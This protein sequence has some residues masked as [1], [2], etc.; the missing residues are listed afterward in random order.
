[1]HGSSCSVSSTS[2]NPTVTHAKPFSFV[3]RELE[4][5]KEKAAALA[6]RS[7]SQESKNLVKTGEEFIKNLRSYQEKATEAAPQVGNQQPVRLYNQA[8]NIQE[9][10]Q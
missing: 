9:F 4:K 10:F 8:V 3:D 1:M 5:V 6:R 7:G 2:S